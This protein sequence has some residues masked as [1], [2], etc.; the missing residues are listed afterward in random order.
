MSAR[1][2][3][4]GVESAIVVKDEANAFRI[5]AWQEKGETWLGLALWNSA[6]TARSY[7]SDHG[8]GAIAV[9]S[10]MS[11]PI[12]SK[13]R[14]YPDCNGIEHRHRLCGAAS[15]WPSPPSSPSNTLWS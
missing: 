5:I 11:A 9:H 15:A 3:T 13:E 1:E 2:T 14:D 8:R 10:T 7:V 12:F 6:S 4:S